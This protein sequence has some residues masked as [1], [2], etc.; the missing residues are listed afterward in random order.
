MDEHPNPSGLD[1]F[2]KILWNLC[3]YCRNIHYKKKDIW[4]GHGSPAHEV[5][6]PKVFDNLVNVMAIELPIWNKYGGKYL[7]GHID[8]LLKIVN[9]IGIGDYKPN[10]TPYFSKNFANSSFLNS[11]PQVAMYALETSNLFDI[12]NILCIT[13]NKKGAWYYKPKPVLRELKLF[14]D[15]H[16]IPAEKRS[17]E[18]YINF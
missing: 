16:F 4:A 5:V 18:D 15:K 7:T 13:Y 12:K 9:V 10:E 8:S 14:L 2:S 11:V 6:L 17:W 1:S 3:Y